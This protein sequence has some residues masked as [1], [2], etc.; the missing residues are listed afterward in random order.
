MTRGANSTPRFRHDE[1]AATVL[2][3]TVRPRCG[4][5]G[6]LFGGFRFAAC[7]T[8]GMPVDGGLAQP[9]DGESL[10][11]E[12]VHASTVAWYP[13]RQRIFSPVESD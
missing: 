3:A 9:A 8:S 13:R 1:W 4:P 5:P 11:R 7:R 6:L 10:I 2:A 12:G